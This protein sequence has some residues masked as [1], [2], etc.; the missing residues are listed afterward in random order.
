[1]GQA[2]LPGRLF[3]QRR[4]PA[5]PEIS[6]GVVLFAAESFNPHFRSHRIPRHVHVRVRLLVHP[7]VFA[8]HF[9]PV[10]RI[11]DESRSLF[12]TGETHGGSERD[13][14]GEDMAAKR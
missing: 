9:S 13:A 6:L 12:R 10:R 4:R 5:P 8:E 3:K 7:L 2:T 1:M 14:H 11:D